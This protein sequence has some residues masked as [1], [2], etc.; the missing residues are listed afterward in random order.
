MGQPISDINICNSLG[1]FMEKKLD[2]ML[3]QH[4]ICCL[5]LLIPIKGAAQNHRDTLRTILI[6]ERKIDPVLATQVIDSNILL[7][8][9]HTGLQQVL[10]LHSNVFVKNYGVGSLSSISIRGSSAAQTAVLW[11]GININNALTGISDFS[12]LPV[13]FFDEIR[14]NENGQ[15]SNALAGN[16]ELRDRHPVFKRGFKINAGAA[17]ESLQNLAAYGSISFSRKK[18]ECS[19][20]GFSQRS[21]NTFSFYHPEKESYDTLKHAHTQTKGVMGDF[22]YRPQTNQLYELHIWQQTNQR[23]IPPALFERFS[24]KN[25]TDKT[26]KA[27]LAYELIVGRWTSRTSLALI[28]DRIIYHDSMI[29][30]SSDVA[31]LNVPVSQTLSWF[32]N[33]RQ[34]FTLLLAGNYAAVLHHDSSSIGRASVCLQYEVEPLWRKVWLSSF[35]QKEVSNV[36]ALPLSAGV[37]LRRKLFRE[38]FLYGSLA[39]NYRMPTLNELYFVPGGNKNLQPETSRNL[40]GGINNRMRKG[41]HQLF[42]KN[43]VFTREVKNWIVW[44][45][46]SI[47]TPHNIQKVWSRGVESDLQYSYTFRDNWRDKG[48]TIMAI[49]A[50]NHS[51]SRFQPKISRFDLHLLYSYTLSTTRESALTNDYSLGKQIPYVPRYQVKIDVGYRYNRFNIRYIYAYT[52]YRFVTTDETQFLLPYNTHHVLAAYEM[53]IRSQH[54][55]L[56]SLRINNLLNQHYESIAGRIMPGRSFSIGLNYSLQR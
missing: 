27:V 14:L 24:T 50:T 46:G 41:Q 4:L 12:I 18:F 25:E 20:K 39:A 45:G 51:R 35:I 6:K 49:I 15:F 56:G 33:Y 31:S 52:G 28:N 48:D 2:I 16:I 36:F 54:Q 47:L 5:L 1:R 11:Q 7:Q 21:K 23:E 34:K 10:Q 26:L 44:Y 40:E 55:L 3:S 17:Y 9:R 42:I 13:S 38:H 53:P 19:L 29:N 43:I 8:Y 30:F 37:N 32:P 22:Y